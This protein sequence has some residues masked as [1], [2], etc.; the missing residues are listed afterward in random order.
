MSRA[1]RL[2]SLLVEQNLGLAC[3][4]LTSCQGIKPVFQFNNLVKANY[5]IST[6]QEVPD[7]EDPFG[8]VGYTSTILVRT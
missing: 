4:G 8:K 7:L 2:S 3:Q 5:S 1:A 6:R